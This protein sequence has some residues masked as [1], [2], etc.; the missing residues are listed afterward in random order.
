MHIAQAALKRALESQVSAEHSL[1]QN[2][3][4]I[5]VQPTECKIVNG[6]GIFSTLI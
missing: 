4:A 6:I 5:I 2:Q 1:K 3:L